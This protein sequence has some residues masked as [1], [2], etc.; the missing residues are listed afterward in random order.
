MRWVPAGK[1]SASVRLNR[2]VVVLWGLVGGGTRIA[3]GRSK[4]KTRLLGGLVL[5]GLVGLLR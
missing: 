2:A 1:A 3:M 4:E 5:L